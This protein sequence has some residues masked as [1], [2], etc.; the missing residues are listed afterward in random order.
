MSTSINRNTLSQYNRIWLD[1][2]TDLANRASS[3]KA[4]LNPTTGKDLN[5]TT[6]QELQLSLLETERAMFV[7]LES[8]RTLTQPGFNELWQVY[9]LEKPKIRQG[10]PLGNL[11]YSNLPNDAPIANPA[12][13]GGSFLIFSNKLR[14]HYNAAAAALTEAYD[15]NKGWFSKLLINTGK[16]ASADV[17]DAKFL[18]PTPATLLRQPGALPSFGKIK[19]G[20]VNKLID[21]QLGTPGSSIM[22]TLVPPP[23]KQKSVQELLGPQSSLTPDALASALI[24]AADAA[25][26]TAD[27]SN[28]STAF[29]LAT[30]AQLLSEISGALS[31]FDLSNASVTLADG[32]VAIALTG[33][34]RLLLDR[35]GTWGI[36]ETFTDANGSRGITTLNSGERYEVQIGNDLS[37]NETWFDTAG[38]KTYGTRYQIGALDPSTTVFA[39]GVTFNWRTDDNGAITDFSPILG[40]AA[41]STNARDF[42]LVID[43]TTLKPSNPDALGSSSSGWGLLGSGAGYNFYNT[44]GFVNNNGGADVG[45]GNLTA[46]GARVGNHTISTFDQIINGLRATEFDAG[47]GDLGFGSPFITAAAQ[48][49]FFGASYA[50]VPY[51]DPV[52]L[53]EG[54]DGVRLSAVPVNF[55]LNADGTAEAL[56]WAAP[57]DPLLVLDL[58][59]DG[60]INNGAE[61]VD[62]TDSGAPLNLL[63]LDENLD[64]KLDGN[65]SSYWDLQV[66]RDRNQDGYASA[67]ER[68]YLSE[69]DITSIN[70]TSITS[71]VPIA[72]KS[73]VKGV[74]ATYGNGQQRTLWDVPFSASAVAAATSTAYAAGI[75]KV[76]SSGQVA[77]VA[78]GPANTVINLANSGATQ[79]IGNAGNDTLIGTG[80]DDWLIGGNGADKFSGG[81]GRDLIVI[82]AEDRQAD[83]DGGADIDTVLVADDRGVL[84][85]LAKAHVE[86]VYGGYG[87]DVLVGGGADNYFIGGGA[88]DDLIIGGSADDVLSGEDG[89]DVIE[90]GAGDDLIRG[91]RGQDQLFGG[92]GNDLIDGGLDNDTIQGGDGNDVIIASGGVDQVDGG[93]GVDLIELAG[94]LEDYSF[95]HNTIGY[96]SEGSWTITDHKNSDGSSV[97]AGEISNRN[98]VQQVS[99]VERFSYKLG[100]RSAVLSFAMPSPLPVNDRIENVSTTGAISIT[101]STLLANDLNF[102][103]LN[104]LGNPAN[105][106]IRLVKWVGDAVG[107]TVTLSGGN[108]VFT[109]T[110][111]YNGPLEFNYQIQVA[112]YSNGYYF[113]NAPMLADSS[114]PS[115]RGEA[116][117]RV[118]LV[119]VATANKITDPE[120]ANQWY[121]SAINATD[122]W[123]DGYTGKGVKVLVLEPSGV[124]AVARQAADLQHPDL[125]A[126]KSASFKD[127]QVYSTH[128]TAVAGVIGAARNGIGGVGVAY[129]VTLDAKGFAPGR[130][131]GSTAIGGLRQDLNTI[132]NYDVVN[133]SWNFS[134]AP[135]GMQSQ[136]SQYALPNELSKDAIRQAATY[137]RGKR[138]T[139]VVFAAGND[140]A[141]GF[142]AGLSALS[143]NPYTITVGAINRANDIALGSSAERFSNRGANILVSAPGSNIVTSGV[144]IE[145]ANGSVFGA[146]TTE[147]QGTSFAT[148]IVSGVAALLLEANPKLS[149]RDVQTILALTARKDFGPGTQAETTW[150]NNS[151]TD[152][153][154]SGL[155]YS[156]DFGFGIVDARAAVRL[157]E[158]WLSEGNDPKRTSAYQNNEAGAIPDLG[159]QVL[160]FDITEAVD[161]EQVLVK[162]QLEHTRWSDLVLTL[163]SPTGTRSILLDR[164]GVQGGVAYLDNPSGQTAFN[165]ELLSVHFRGESSVGTWQLVIEDKAAGGVGSGSVLGAL[166][167]IGA[168]PGVLKRYLLT[169]EYAGGWNVGGIPATP[170]ELNAAAV[171]GNLRI[172]LSGS[173]ASSVAGKVLNVSA[174]IDR[175]LGGDGA[176]TLLGG[177][178]NETIFGGRGNDFI[179]GGAGSDKL[180]GS[181]GNDTLSGG[182][183]QDLLVGGNGVDTLTGGS[184]SD[185]FLIDGDTASSTTIKD[186]ALGAGGDTLQI[187]SQTKLSFSSVVQTVIGSNLYLN[188]NVAGGQSTV[189]LEGVNTRLDARQ[190]RTLAANEQVSVDP[191]TGGFVGGN[192]VYVKPEFVVRTYQPHETGFVLTDSL[193]PSS[194]GFIPI[195]APGFKFVHVSEGSATAAPG[196]QI[197]IVFGA[198]IRSG[199]QI[200]YSRFTILNKDVKDA[201]WPGVLHDDPTV[202]SLLQTNSYANSSVTPYLLENVHWTEGSDADELLVAGVTPS[203]PAQISQAVWDKAIAELGPRTY[204][205]NGGNDEIVGDAT[206]EILQGGA[207]F[208]TL[209][210]NG[211]NDVLYGGS[212]ADQFIF[213]PGDGIDTIQDLEDIDILRFKSVASV[214]RDIAFS[215]VT[216]ENFQATTALR[217]GTADAV[218]FATQFSVAQLT[219]NDLALYSAEFDTGRQ[220]VLLDVR[221]PTEGADVIVQ[222][223]ATPFSAISTLGGNDVIYALEQNLLSI[224]AGD[225]QDIV[226]ALEGG[227]TINGGAGDDLIE[228]TAAAAPVATDILIGGA[229]NDTLRAGAYGAVLYGDDLANSLNGADKLFGGLGNDTLYGGGGNDALFGGL[230]NDSLD[231]GDGNDYLNGGAGD[232]HLYG[233]QG[234]DALYGDAGV[235]LLDGGAGNDQLIGGIDNDT[236]TGGAGDDFILTDSGSDIVRV[237]ANS[238]ND[239]IDGLSGLD[240]IEFVGLNRN[241]INF[242]L[243]NN[244]VQV[245]L[246]WGTSNSVTLNKYSLSTK[247]AFA[248]LSGTL[249]DIFNRNGYNPDGSFDF[250]G[251]FDTQLQGDPNKVGTVV[252]GANNDQ[253]YGGPIA[254]TDA[255]Y[256][257]VVGR[258]GDDSLAGGLSGAI[259]DGGVGDDK[260]RGSNGITLVRDTFHGGHDTL[261][262]QEGITPESLRYYRIP[263]PLETAK[264]Q[265]NA[266][267][268]DSYTLATPTGAE[269][270]LPNGE[271][272]ILEPGTSR[273][274]NAYYNYSDPIYQH[275]DTLRIQS[276]DGKFTVDIAGYFE[277]GKLKNDVANIVFTTVFDA[278]GNSLSYKLDDLVTANVK[279]SQYQIKSGGSSDYNDLAGLNYYLFGNYRTG[280][281]QPAFSPYNTSPGFISYYYGNQYSQET[282][283]RVIIGGQAGTRLTGKVKV[284]ENTYV[285]DSWTRQTSPVR[286]SDIV[287]ADQ[288]AASI[289]RNRSG[290]DN[291]TYYNNYPTPSG[292]L[293]ENFATIAVAL[294]DRILGFGG[295]DTIYAGGAYV[296]TLFSGTRGFARY[297]DDR[298]DRYYAAAFGQPSS[299]L[300]D[301]VNGGDGDDTYIYRRGDGAL[302]IIATD[303]RFGGADGFDTLDLTDFTR[304]E[305]SISGGNVNGSLRISVPNPYPYATPYGQSPLR[306]TF[307]INVFAGAEGRLQ[308]DQIKFSD[309]VINIQ[310]FILAHAASLLPKI[311]A[312]S[313]PY[314]ETKLAKAPATLNQAIVPDDFGTI[315]LGLTAGSVIEGSPISDFILVP[316]NGVAQGYE[317]GD[318][319]VIDPD[320][321]DFAVI[322]VD[323]GDG[324]FF[325]SLKELSTTSTPIT[326]QDYARDY[327]YAA[328]ASVQNPSLTYLGKTETEWLASGVLPVRDYEYSRNFSSE[329]FRIENWSSRSLQ[330]KLGKLQ[331]VSTGS[332]ASYTLANWHPADEASDVVADALISWKTGTINAQTGLFIGPTMDHYAVLVGVADAWGMVSSSTLAGLLT[333]KYGTQGDDYISDF[334]TNSAGVAEVFALGGNDTIA[335]YSSDSFDTN[336]G[337]YVGLK[338]ILHGGS[339][340]DLLDGG[341]GDDSLFG[342]DGDDRLI[343]GFGNDYLVS[344]AGSDTLIGGTGDDIY[345]I[346]IDDVIEESAGN[347]VFGTIVRGVWTEGMVEQ[348]SPSQLVALGINESYAPN[349][350]YGP[351]SS[352]STNLNA[353]DGLHQQT[354]FVPEYNYSPA[355][356]NSLWEYNRN[357]YY[358]T[359]I[360]HTAHLTTTIQDLSLSSG[361]DEVRAD[362]DLDLSSAKFANIENGALLGDT[363]HLLTGSALVN[364]LTGNGAGSTLAGLAGD[365]VYVVTREGDTIIEAANAGHDRIETSIDILQLANNIEDLVSTGISL[366][367]FGNNL[368]NRIVGDVGNNI[369]DGGSGTDT[370]EGGGGDD[371]YYVDNANDVVIETAGNGRDVVW[372]ARGY[373]LND[374]GNND[375]EELRASS[376]SGVQLTGNSLNNLLVGGAGDDTLSGGLGVDRLFGGAGDDVYVADSVDVLE[377]SV[378]AGIDTVQSNLLSYTLGANFENLTLTGAALISG[379]GNNLNNVITGN[380]AANSLYGGDGNDTL[381]GGGG[382]DYLQGGAGA[383]T[384][385]F[386]SADLY[387]QSYG[388]YWNIYRNNIVGDSQDTLKFTDL[389]SDQIGIERGSFYYDS[390]ASFA[391]W[392]ASAAESNIRFYNLNESYSE[393]GVYLEGFFDINLTGESSNRLQQIEF[394]DGVTLSYQ[395]I[396]ER[397]MQT[398]IGS[399]EVGGFSTDETIDGL[400]GNDRLYG[401]GGN[402]YLLGSAGF[403]T[404]DGGTGNDILSGGT[405]DDTLYGGTGNNLLVSGSGGDTLNGATG[406]E[407]FIGGTGN[408][409]LDTGSGFDIIAFN[410]GDGV[411]TVAPS[412]GQDNTLSLGGG[413]RNTDLYFSKSS[414]DLILDTGSSESIVFKNWYAA[415][416]NKSALNLQ[417]IEEA[418]ADFALGGT[419]PLTDNKVEQ[420]NFA[421]LVNSFDQARTATP[422]LTTWAL[423][424]ALLTFYLGGGDTQA[425][426]GDLAYQYGK[427]GS[428]AN[429]GLTAAQSTLANTQFGQTNQAINQPGLSDGLVRLSA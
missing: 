410:R 359:Y 191:V 94:G 144:Q 105:N 167:V 259:L 125:I 266:V 37:V 335:A 45:V 407:L 111:G 428:L 195:N 413:I 285:Y 128:A 351:Y 51:I 97:A 332:N 378:N 239:I 134:S 362:F 84:L 101:A 202:I 181:I 276:F 150:Y 265:K 415:A 166:E 131:P 310:D 329:E 264:L 90:G 112:T 99:N 237:D 294:P 275:Y 38:T 87:N 183:G 352:Y 53:D 11:I 388:T 317:G 107:G 19:D 320:T 279:D 281:Y 48:S 404:L 292:Y 318:V 65:D 72:G 247:L 25:L 253:L 64:G 293:Y 361:T 2:W 33:S 230:G 141:S 109:P 22:D 381:R 403:D 54:R 333:A 155:H 23:T 386:S 323:R 56:P 257:Y 392:H 372:A 110:P 311:A 168:A 250:V 91:H 70:L 390:D 139:V 210:G 278:Q 57:T 376:D 88:G 224:D 309:S 184:E 46:N 366:N 258:Q 261:V 32:S 367:L 251:M 130:T 426:G 327:F 219:L 347:Q 269:T 44:I 384:Y 169:D 330:V 252:G 297:Y 305:V 13:S 148:P 159:Q 233:G 20:V 95:V 326:L 143:A 319:F 146:D 298:L 127:T 29:A 133:N 377:E 217:Y 213:N 3:I 245:K 216:K 126:N 158:N 328:F 66:W 26:K 375:I 21:G 304:A 61:L 80:A 368:D 270:K 186:F 41:T 176:D 83:I 35:T 399:D 207:G 152:W 420:F 234:N 382:G 273:Y 218:M 379:I 228:I 363:A 93:A 360:K 100:N 163:I 16:A 242:A 63:K 283:G 31:P 108:I 389:C 344:G 346:D 287:N 268:G 160:T 411:D 182:A 28:S 337:T 418:A 401:L 236:L 200:G 271:F 313:R 393:Q 248:D 62:L 343:G 307:D 174:G 208:D 400:A 89:N 342:G 391:T 136:G 140:R 58:N 24:A 113:Y 355:P 60:R 129:D 157:A 229:G 405:E 171:S 119:P 82:D 288:Y 27:G 43:T 78:N 338:H 14:D 385:L 416:A 102:L 193:T 240:T 308:V 262:I 429:I 353:F 77:L 154:G 123:N 280:T 59:N 156:H 246:S 241:Q 371:A 34:R 115:V 380:A 69:L 106:D 395:Q 299:S 104:N 300:G 397:L 284:T 71:P 422:T 290:Y 232:D 50:T 190:L 185:V 124:F 260:F 215:N 302:S 303:D 226:F 47:L 177:S 398:S 201:R 74:V 249:K 73:G 255:A 364:R 206:A 1:Q 194:T 334:A 135:W 67:E 396:R 175:L 198:L 151:D 42:D 419:N 15:E 7:H 121:L 149:Y 9:N 137:G 349:S 358:V 244:G 138:G 357:G 10:V 81:A 345:V 321:A 387:A 256:W 165:G 170:S 223:K 222:K 238:G 394:S 39:D 92:A 162:L 18:L 350:F 373:T 147:T 153:N 142:D 179:D 204:W 354:W 30:N 341:A 272:P 189:V 164:T 55:D 132:Q 243:L 267:Y 12:T 221:T 4:A 212:D 52:V 306:T 296:E 225:G 203:K 315:G 263:N 205:G 312:D 286:R 180:D 231:G 86:V 211:G 356:P 75:N 383:D 274:N 196:Q 235:N 161:V 116:K 187:R 79:A 295:N 348:V 340:N 197:V 76:S 408:D 98:G 40:N 291:H 427:T 49:L 369:L 145:N 322:P 370:L 412:S 425:I 85:N 406:R 117:A 289:S 402:D 374:S 325:A 209:T 114:D 254:S 339:G 282:D 417:L 118:L 96:S 314:T 301:Q 421:G 424:N 423:S 336:T 365:D 5:S 227:N 220:T 331:R 316:R 173:S 277:T 199:G 17:L 6:N 409:S 324:V 192:V 36:S 178:G 120:F 122:V 103:H 68:Q 8:I 188:F 172:D 414:N 214:S